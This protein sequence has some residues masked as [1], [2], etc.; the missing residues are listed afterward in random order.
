MEG[1]FNELKVYVL[2]KL[3]WNKDRDVNKLISDFN[4]YSFGKE[5]AEKMD[6]FVFFNDTY[7]EQ[8]ASSGATYKLAGIYDVGSS[9]LISEETLNV[10]YVRRAE[11]FVLQ[12]KDIIESDTSISQKLRNTRLDNLSK[13]EAMIDMMKYLNYDSLWKTTNAEK[14][15]FLRSFYARVKKIRDLTYFGGKTWG[16][17]AEEFAK[18]GIY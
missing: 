1:Y 7:F 12:A 10:D 9:W 13:A 3:M 17:V 4:R 6:D 15:K 8:V 16:T 2:S 14:D 11:S 5:A 18:Y